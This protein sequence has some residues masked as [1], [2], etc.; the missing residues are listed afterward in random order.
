MI[1]PKKPIRKQTIPKIKSPVNMLDT[2]S[3][4]LASIELAADNPKAMNKKAP[5]I[6]IN[7]KICSILLVL[8]C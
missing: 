8:N 7:I 5:I 1:N 3:L 4:S 2:I 6:A